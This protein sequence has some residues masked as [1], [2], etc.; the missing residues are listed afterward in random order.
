MMAVSKEVLPAIDQHIVHIL[1]SMG[2]YYQL[3]WH[4]EVPLSFS[5]P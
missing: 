3:Q 4:Q 2:L 1:V 5:G